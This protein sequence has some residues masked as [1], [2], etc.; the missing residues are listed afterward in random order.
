M[1]D[2]AT[3]FHFITPL[4]LGYIIEFYSYGY[5]ELFSFKSLSSYFF[6]H[7]KINFTYHFSFLLIRK[8]N[9]LECLFIPGKFLSMWG[10]EPHPIEWG[11]AWESTDMPGASTLAYFCIS[12]G[13]SEQIS[14]LTTS[15][16]V[17]LQPFWSS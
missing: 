11:P 5:F 14:I 1:G 17:N 16:G 3:I 13:D 6:S 2:A 4:N 8:H 10:Q 7:F 12:T 9:K 15:P